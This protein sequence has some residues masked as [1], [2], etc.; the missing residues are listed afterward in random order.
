MKWTQ[1]TAPIFDAYVTIHG[2]KIFVAGGASPVAVAQH[3][4][5]IYDINTNQWDWLPSSGHYFGVPH[6]IDGKLAVIGRRLSATKQRT[7]RMST[8]DETS[9]AWISYRLS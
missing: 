4:I 1:L 2:K 3:E 7:N 9:Q 5:Y 8:F 6:M